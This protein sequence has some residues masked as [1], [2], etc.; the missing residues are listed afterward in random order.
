MSPSSSGNLK[1]IYGP[2]LWLRLRF[3]SFSKHASLP[4][5]KKIVKRH[6]L[7]VVIWRLAK[8]PSASYTWICALGLI[9]GHGKWTKT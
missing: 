9:H 4:N 8:T 2:L 5:L 7:I 1:I 6:I 3:F